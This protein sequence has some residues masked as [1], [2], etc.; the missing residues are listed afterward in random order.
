MNFLFVL[1]PIYNCCDRMCDMT[2]LINLQ[3]KPLRK[4]MLVIDGIFQLVK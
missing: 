3:K 2:A 4:C 1:I